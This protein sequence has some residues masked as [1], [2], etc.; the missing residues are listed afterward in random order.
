MER[1]GPAA[2]VLVTAI[3]AIA[4]L[5]ALALVRGIDGALFMPVIGVIAL[6]AGVK[7]RDVL[8]GR[9]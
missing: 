1:K 6:I 3:V 4:G 8:D 2:A 5:Y 9:K 7:V